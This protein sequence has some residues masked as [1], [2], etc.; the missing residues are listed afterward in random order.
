[1]DGPTENINLAEEERLEENREL[2]ARASNGLANLQLAHNVPVNHAAMDTVIDAL[3][4]SMHPALKPIVWNPPAN[5]PDLWSNDEAKA[6]ATMK[7]IEDISKKRECNDDFHTWLCSISRMPV[8]IWP[9]WVEDEFG[10]HWVVVYWTSEQRDNPKNPTEE[11]RYITD[12]R[13]LDPALDYAYYTGGFRTHDAR[14]RRITQRLH[15]LLR[16]FRRV[17]ALEDVCVLRWNARE[18]GLLQPANGLLRG[19]HANFYLEAGDAA[20]GERVYAVVKQL[21]AGILDIARA[22]QYEEADRYWELPHYRYLGQLTHVDPALA[23]ME[24]A[25]IC[26][27]KCMQAQDFRARIAVRPLRGDDPK[28][29]VE[30]DGETRYLAPDAL[31][32]PHA[33][34]NHVVN[35]DIAEWRLEQNLWKQEEEERRKRDVVDVTDD[36]DLDQ[37]EQ[38]Q[39]PDVIDDSDPDASDVEMVRKLNPAACASELADVGKSGPPT[40]TSIKRKQPLGPSPLSQDNGNGD[41]GYNSDNNDGSPAPKKRKN[42][43]DGNVPGRPKV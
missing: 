27:W 11:R 3:W 40:M 10:A 6:E 19:Y 32:R 24:M 30:V 17:Y 37:Q 18:P 2:H 34:V 42:G 41:E 36:M 22:P 4:E 20:T 15:R 21:L 7:A 5:G 39:G 35:W 38:G 31:R 23:R 9:L 16:L 29:P 43:L 33:L 12:I 25:G 28:I 13:L 26:A 8:I 14:R 1:M